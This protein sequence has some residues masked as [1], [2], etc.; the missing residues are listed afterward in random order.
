M[1]SSLSCRKEGSLVGAISRGCVIGVKVVVQ[2]VVSLLIYTALLQF[3]DASFVWLAR[4]G[5]FENIDLTV[6]SS[7]NP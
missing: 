3:V 2:V 1:L 6:R 7:R 4:R 5:G